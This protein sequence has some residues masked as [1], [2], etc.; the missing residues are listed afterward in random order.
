MPICQLSHLFFSLVPTSFHCWLF[1]LGVGLSGNSISQQFSST[2]FVSKL[3]E[4]IFIFG[5][6]STL[7]VFCN[8]SN[9]RIA[10]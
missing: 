3:F 9:E 5:V 6:T 1:G 10:P 8:S 4:L 2:S 7:I